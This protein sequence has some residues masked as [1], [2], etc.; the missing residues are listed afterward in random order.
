MLR[1]ALHVFG[2]F[3]APAVFWPSHAMAL[4]VPVS[5]KMAVVTQTYDISTNVPT[6]CRARIQEAAGRWNG[7]SKFALTFGTLKTGASIGSVSTPNILFSMEPGSAFG[8]Q[9][10]SSAQT[11]P[12]VAT[13][14]QTFVSPYPN[15]AGST[16]LYKMKDADV[17][18]NADI[19]ASGD[20]L[21]KISASTPLASNKLDWGRT[22]AHE[23]GHVAGLDHHGTNNNTCLLYN[24]TLY[25]IAAHNPCPDEVTVI[26]ALYP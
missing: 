22:F 23:F 15:A 18:L 26:K 16:T 25:A 11:V 20:Y 8:A 5:W 7:L 1:S 4:S 6:D 10:A 3:A 9:S 17:R 24:A 14:A 12:W 21:C 13:P 2:M 19:W